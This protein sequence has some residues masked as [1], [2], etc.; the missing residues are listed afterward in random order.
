MSLLV[1]G[2]PIYGQGDF[3]PL[4]EHIGFVE[5]LPRERLYPEIGVSA[6]TFLRD[7]RSYIR[8]GKLLIDI[9]LAAGYQDLES[10]AEYGYDQGYSTEE[11]IR[12]SVG[13]VRP[14][15]AS[16]PRLMAEPGE[17]MSDFSLRLR[18]HQLYEVK[19]EGDPYQVRLTC[20]GRYDPE[21]YL[22]DT[23]SV[24]AGLDETGEA[25]LLQDTVD[26]V[27]IHTLKN[28]IPFNGM[29]VKSQFGEGDPFD[30]PNYYASRA[31]APM[32]F[33]MYRRMGKHF[34]EA[35]YTH[36]PYVRAMEQV[37]AHFNPKTDELARMPSGYHAFRRGGVMPQGSR[38]SVYGDDRNNDRE[39]INYIGRDESLTTRMKGLLSLLAM[40]VPQNRAAERQYANTKVHLRAAGESGWDMCLSRFANGGDLSQINTTNIIPLD[41]QCMMIDGGRMLAHSYKLLAAKASR[42][43]DLNLEL[44]Y[45]FEKSSSYLTTWR[46]ESNSLKNMPG[47]TRS[48]PIMT[49]SWLV[50]QAH[51]T[52]C[53]V[54]LGS[55]VLKRYR[56]RRDMFSGLWLRVRTAILI[57]LFQLPA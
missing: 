34:G 36:M 49:S 22:L 31:Q 27:T 15:T 35:V 53:V 48:V 28:G 12:Q 18:T 8:D 24:T 39:N 13:E 5:P 46:A 57:G 47:M 3:P 44:E 20:D 30:E 45:L 38:F 54:T 32:I 16:R 2:P 1:E 43:G 14:Y 10:L 11:I 40:Q 23:G 17:A 42:E 26:V 4:R 7:G 56:L 25:E 21:I 29:R 37:W 19:V 9:M 33:D 41:L 50:Q 52:A 51:M 55:S 6:T